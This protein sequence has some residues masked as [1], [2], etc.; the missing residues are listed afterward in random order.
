[1]SVAAPLRSRARAGFGRHPLSAHHQRHN[2]PETLGRNGAAHPRAGDPWRRET[3]RSRWSSS[4]GCRSGET[5]IAGVLHRSPTNRRAAPGGPLPANPHGH[6]P[7]G[8]DR[9]CTGSSA[10][11]TRCRPYLAA[12]MGWHPPGMSPQRPDRPHNSHSWPCCNRFRPF[13]TDR[14]GH[15]SR[16][17]LSPTQTLFADLLMTSRDT[18]PRLARLGWIQ[19]IG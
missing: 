17:R 4:R 5:H 9:I 14:C 12:R 19:P 7:A 13:P 1:M 10:I 3:Q 15:Q 8:R 6:R 2:Q 18:C 11:R 16:A